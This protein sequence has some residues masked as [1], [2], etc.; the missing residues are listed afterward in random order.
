MSPDC[1]I[2][3][4]FF[5]NSSFFFMTMFISGDATATSTTL[6]TAP[7]WYCYVRKK[8]IFKTA[9]VFIKCW[10][11]KLVNGAEKI[12]IFFYLFIFLKRHEA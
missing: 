5:T 8:N 11:R 7:Y 3:E 2:L 6:T 12:I 9:V 10:F 1:C 4:V